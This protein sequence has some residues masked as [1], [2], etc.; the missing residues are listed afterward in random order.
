MATKPQDPP[1]RG[2]GLE[3]LHIWQIQ[4]VRDVLVVAALVGLVWLGYALR[5]VTVPLLVALLLAYLFEPLVARLTRRGRISRAM[6]VVGILGSVGV[7]VVAVLAMLLPT[8]IGETYELLDDFKSGKVRLQV[9]DLARHVPQAWRDRAQPIIEIL[10]SGPGP[11]DG[12]AIP[13]DEPAPPIEA[14]SPGAGAGADDL[15][16]M[17]RQEIARARTEDAGRRE[18]WLGMARGGARTVRRVLG[19]VIELGFLAF[20]IPFYFFFFSVSYPA[21]AR[22]ARSLLPESGRSRTVELLKKMDG[23]VAG[24]VRGRIVI[25]LI[26]GVMLAVGWA[27]C[28]VPHS[29]MLGLVVGVFC[30]IPY[31]GLI[32]IPV[33]VALL[34]YGELGGQQAGDAMAWWQILLWPTLVFA[35]VQLIEGYAL[36]PLIAGKATG[37]DPVTILVAVLAGGSIMGV[38]GMLLA[39]PLAACLKIFIT[40]VVLPRVRAWTAGEVADPLPIGGKKPPSLT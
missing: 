12:G 23:V 26:M 8:V 38:Y 28:G 11:A 19:G 21:V 40:D 35:I 24:F 17:I 27:V 5:A 13:T 7:V 2:A 22:F 34:A 10:P 32:G 31:L 33:A 1:L 36:T 9:E 3:R 29:I 15:R 39:I 16:L 18:D 14:E 20:L 37:L 25:A 30:A 4:A 6:V